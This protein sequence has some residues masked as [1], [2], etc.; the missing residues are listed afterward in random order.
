MLCYKFGDVDC[1]Y[2]SMICPWGIFLAQDLRKILQH[3]WISRR[4]ISRRMAGAYIHPVHAIHTDH[5]EEWS[6]NPIDDLASFVGIEYYW[7]GKCLSSSD[8]LRGA[9]YNGC[10]PWS[11]FGKLWATAL[12]TRF[13][14]MGQMWW[15]W[16]LVSQ[17]KYHMLGRRL[18]LHGG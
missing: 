15:P 7:V 17:C 11:S 8:G 4:Q 10:V 2:S 13:G 9:D 3:W 12:T 16:P 6:E 1:W 18:S 14:N 5:W